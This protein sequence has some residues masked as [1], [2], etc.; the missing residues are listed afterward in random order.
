MIQRKNFLFSALLLVLP[1]LSGCNSG[2]D[3]IICEDGSTPTPGP[4]TPATITE[5]L[6]QLG[7]P[8]QRL[9]YDPTRQN[10]FTGALGTRVTIPARAF[11]RANGQPVTG[12]VVLELR[13]IF[14]KAGM[15]LSNRPTVASGR[16]LESAGEVFLQPAQ[17]S[18]LRLSPGTTIQIQTQNPPNL[19]SRDSMRL[20]V[21]PVPG[22][23]TTNCFTW[24]LNPDPQSSLSPTPSGYRLEIGKVLFD[25]GMGWFNCDRFYGTPSPQPIVVDVAGPDV[26][27]QQNTMVFAAFRAFNGSLR[28]CDFTA[29]GTFQT[30]GAPAGAAISVV[31]IQTLGG[32]LYYGR[33]DGVVAAGTRFSPVL[34][35]TTR[36]ALVADLATL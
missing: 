13:E 34:R 22:V 14:D 15:I 26:D 23:N 19:A 31:V 17:D 5:V 16:L 30:G 29:P 9:T 20:F 11:L 10:Q 24:L 6:T 32:K 1:L 28:V 27:P 4:G 35:E 21:A 33:Q 36:A 12:P 18:S 7:A 3:L 8:T 25:A 2:S